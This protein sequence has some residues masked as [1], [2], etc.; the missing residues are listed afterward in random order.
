MRYLGYFVIGVSPFPLAST[1]P[2]WHW[3][4]IITISFTLLAKLMWQSKSETPATSRQSTVA[5]ALMTLVVIWGYTQATAPYKISQLLQLDAPFSLDVIHHFLSINREA[6]LTTTSRLLGT[7]IFFVALSTFYSQLQENHG[8][9][10]AAFFCFVSLVVSA[11]ALYGFSIFV[12]GNKTVLWYDK[13]ASLGSLTGTFINRNNF[14]AF[15]GLGLQS[16]IAYALYHFRQKARP[17]NAE[18][19]NTSISLLKNTW[20]LILV[21]ILLVTSLILTSS[22]AGI[23]SVI[24]SIFVLLCMSSEFQFRNILRMKNVATFLILIFSILFLINFSGE[25][26]IDRGIEDYSLTQRLNSLPQI[27]NAYQNTPIIGSGLGTFSEV[28]PIFRK[29]TVDLHLVRAHNDYFELAITAGPIVVTM[30]VLAIILIMIRI[31]LNLKGRGPLRP[32][33]AVS[34]S[35]TFQIASHSIVDFPLQIP[36]IA[37]LWC[38]ILSVGLGITHNRRI[39]HSNV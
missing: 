35:S 10:E 1:A 15:L 38:G 3:F 31:T 26:L 19:L 14:A 27:F 13:S 37:F 18:L 5:F 39:I 6:T 24:A 9:V 22:R 16:T 28:F 20:W 30:F 34:I 36:P 21:I 33:M 4:W 12:S 29:A 11:Y 25:A 23:A 17:S 7:F 2:I 8:K 32:L